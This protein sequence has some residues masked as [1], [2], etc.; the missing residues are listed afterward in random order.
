MNSNLR[1]WL[2]SLSPEQREMVEEK[3]GAIAA[4]NAEEK[5]INAMRKAA[6]LPEVDVDPNKDKIV[7]T[8][9]KAAGLE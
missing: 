3:L 6:G 5:A 8:A 1:K 7:D 4:E 2:I 9:R